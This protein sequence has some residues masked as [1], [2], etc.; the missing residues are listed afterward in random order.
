MPATASYAVD[1]IIG[2]QIQGHAIDEQ[3]TTPCPVR[4]AC[5]APFVVSSNVANGIDI[6][7]QR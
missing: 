6:Q 7:E 4:E 2:G 5:V 1:D 3:R